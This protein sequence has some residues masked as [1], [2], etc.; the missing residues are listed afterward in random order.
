MTLTCEFDRDQGRIKATAG[1]GT[2]PN[3]GRLQTYN[4]LTT[5]TNCGPPKLLARV[6]QHP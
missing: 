5:P 1:P 6:Q 2:V 4:Q 3:A